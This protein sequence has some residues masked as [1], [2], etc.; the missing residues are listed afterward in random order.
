MSGIGRGVGEI[1]AAPMHAELTSK[2]LD[3]LR[4]AFPQITTVAALVNS[5]P[6][7]SSHKLAFEQTETAARSSSGLLCSGS[8]P[9]RW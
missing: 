3:L 8:T 5:N 4:S 2:R 9:K 7:N 6:A 1:F